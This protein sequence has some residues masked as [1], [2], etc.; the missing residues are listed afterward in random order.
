VGALLVTL[1]FK[2]ISTF[3]EN[4][5]EKLKTQ[6]SL[7]NHRFFSR[8]LVWMTPENSGKGRTVPV[9]RLEKYSTYIT[10]TAFWSAMEKENNTGNGAYLQAKNIQRKL[11]RERKAESQ[12]KKKMNEKKTVGRSDNGR[13]GLVSAARAGK[14]Q[15]HFAGRLFG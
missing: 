14:K 4:V 3:F 9:R 12:I 10:S 7:Y 6:V 5:C 11:A 15:N 2:T 1:T 13:K 8:A